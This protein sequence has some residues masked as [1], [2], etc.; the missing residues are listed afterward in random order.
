MADGTVALRLAPGR[1]GGRG[2]LRHAG[3]RLART[4]R[5]HAAALVGA[6]RRPAAA[7]RVQSRRPC[8]RAGGA[9]AR[10]RHLA[11]ALSERRDAG[12]P[13]TAA[14]AGVFLHLGV[15]AGPG[16]AGTSAST[17][18]SALLPDKAAIQLND[19]HPA[20]AV[21]ELMRILVDRARAAVGRGVADH[22]RHHLLH[23]PHAAARGAGELAGVADGA[24][25]AA[26][27][28]DHL[29][30]QPAASGRGL[31]SAA[32][33]RAAARRGVADRRATPAG[34]CAWARSPSSART[35]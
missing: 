7:R 12:G 26:P 9:G 18:T 19:T 17:A 10:Q 4:L 8:R 23:Q 27:H 29:P 35:R 6:G 11:G 22:H 2:R 1:D 21:A 13:G 32:A 24:A 33:G 25:A 5:Q 16:R 14:A 30:D 31:R 28:A 34:A 3:R 15:A 20:I